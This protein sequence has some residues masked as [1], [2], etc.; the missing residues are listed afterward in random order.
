M[1]LAIECIVLC[2]VFSLAIMIPLY[3]NPIG[4][5]MSYPKKIR[6]RVESL[7][8]YKDSIKKTEKTIL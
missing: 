8:Q 1:I 5:I 2:I 3:K 7:P 6:E 4:Q